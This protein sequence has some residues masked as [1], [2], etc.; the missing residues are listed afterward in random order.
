MSKQVS[1]TDVR[2][3]A[4]RVCQAAEEFCRLDRRRRQDFMTTQEDEDQLCA[5]WKLALASLE[6]AVKDWQDA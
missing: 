4:N 3:L 5:D 2:T 6:S 1:G